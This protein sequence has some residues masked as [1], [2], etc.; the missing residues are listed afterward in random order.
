MTGG[1]ERKRKREQ[2]EHE[3]KQQKRTA[4]TRPHVLLLDLVKQWLSTPRVKLYSRI[5]RKCDKRNHV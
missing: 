5:N 3:Q 2:K 4:A 1:G